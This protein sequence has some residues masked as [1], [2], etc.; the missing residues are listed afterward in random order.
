V[1][2]SG[3]PVSDATKRGIYLG[4]TTDSLVTG[5]VTHHNSEAGIYL[6]AGTARVTVEGNESYANA[7]GYT[8]AAP[9]IDVRGDDNVVVRNRTHDNEDTGLQFYTGAARNLVAANLTYHNGDHGID[10]LGATDQVIVGNTVVANVTAGINLEGGSTGGTVRNNISIDN[11]IGSPRTKGNIRVDSASIAGTSVD[12]DLVNLSAAGYLMVWGSSSYTS[13]SAFRA[14]T[15][16]EQHGLQ[17]DPL[18]RSPATADY[19]L[20]SGSPAVDSADSGAPG[21]QSS[22]LAGLP[23]VDDPATVDS[24]VGPRSYDDRGSFELQP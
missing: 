10:D 9:G 13:L 8:R 4:T 23:R 19:G 11:G 14:A 7:R 16:Q 3:Q 18:F 21:E 1:S 5:N 22:D 6:D 24:G 17:G 15:G 2:Y 12:F 20:Q